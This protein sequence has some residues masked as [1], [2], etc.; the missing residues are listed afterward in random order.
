VTTELRTR[1]RPD[2]MQFDLAASGFGPVEGPVEGPTDEVERI[3][4]VPRR[5]RIGSIE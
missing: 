5:V 3:P 4:P 1:D 2:A